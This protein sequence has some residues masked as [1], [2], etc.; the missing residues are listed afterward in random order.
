MNDWRLAGQERYL[1]KA[2]LVKTRFHPYADYD[3]D[4]CSFC[5]S[6][7]SAAEEDLHVGYASLDG[8]HMICETCYMDFKELF[9]WTL[10]ENA[11]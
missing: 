4:H 10:K 6:K 3:H 2:I 7:F 1:S 8:R 5:W 9:Q 11:I